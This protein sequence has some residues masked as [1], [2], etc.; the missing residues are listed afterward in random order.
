VA[1]APAVR[2]LM[3][4]MSDKAR[5]GPPAEPEHAAAGGLGRRGHHGGGTSVVVQRDV[6]D[7]GVHATGRPATTAGRVC[8]PDPLV[9]CPRSVQRLDAEPG[10]RP[11]KTGRLSRSDDGE[12]RT[13]LEMADEVIRSA[14]AGQLVLEQNLGSLCE[15][16]T[17]SRSRRSPPNSSSVVRCN[18]SR[19]LSSPR[20]VDNRLSTGFGQIN[21][22]DDGR[23]RGQTGI[24][25]TP[26]PSG[27]VAPS[28]QQSLKPPPTLAPDRRSHLTG[29]PHT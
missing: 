8:K 27:L 7:T 26:A 14:L 29:G 20:F 13:C 21:D 11:S 23:R 10:S 16:H 15:Q 5:T 17:D 18:R 9:T 4:I 3:E 19:R 12:S 2:T 1:G 24:V 25:Q 28:R 6:V 22:F